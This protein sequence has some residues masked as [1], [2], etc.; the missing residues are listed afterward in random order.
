MQAMQASKI[1][2]PH[3][4]RLRPREEF[5]DAHFVLQEPTASI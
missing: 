1:L 2:V 5:G 3:A 4:A